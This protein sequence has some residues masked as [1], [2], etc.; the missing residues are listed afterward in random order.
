MQAAI[1]LFD[2]SARDATCQPVQAFLTIS[3][4]EGQGP[5][6]SVLHFLSRL[7]HFHTILNKS[8]FL[9]SISNLSKDHQQADDQLKLH[10]LKGNL[11]ISF[12]MVSAESCLAR[13]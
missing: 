13:R 11:D 4:L 5:K 7:C 10:R 2:C 6:E 1:E 12:K 9:N 3:N 8:F